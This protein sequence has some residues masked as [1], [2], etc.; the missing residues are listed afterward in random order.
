MKT[1]LMKV[2]AALGLVSMLAV[3]A[4]TASFAAPDKTFVFH[5]F[6]PNVDRQEEKTL[7]E[8]FL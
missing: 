6:D 2:L 3:G 5:K 1:N 4:S 8:R 7:C